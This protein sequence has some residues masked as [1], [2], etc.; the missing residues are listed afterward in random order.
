MASLRPIIPRATLT[1]HSAQLQR[2]LLPS[3]KATTLH[4]NASSST[5]PP[6]PRLLEKP[7]RF[8]PP[9]HGAR[10]PRSRRTPSY[11]GAPLTSEQRTRRYPHMFPA[12][13]TW[14]FWFLTNRILHVGITLSILISLVF[15]IQIG[16]FVHNTPYYELLPPKGEF[17][18]NPLSFLGRYVQVYQMHIDWMSTQTAERRRQKVEDVRK[19]SEYRKAHGMDKDD[20]VFGGWTAKSDAEVMG[21]GMREGGDMGVMPAV[22]ERQGVTGTGEGAGRVDGY[23]DFDGN[24]Q[25]ARKKWFGI[26]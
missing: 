25:A 14:T 13:G 7:E 10:L 15:A 12:E 19:R 20:G 3:I 6:K 8:N 16:D 24:R 1:L 9:S 2:R 21:P 18:R 11:P 22:G 5:L 23:V 17:W 26:W 4:R